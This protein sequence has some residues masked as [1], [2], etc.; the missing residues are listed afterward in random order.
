VI[1]KVQE[2]DLVPGDENECIEMKID[3]LIITVNE[4]IDAVTCLHKKVSP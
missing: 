1:E 3:E 4:L 2:L